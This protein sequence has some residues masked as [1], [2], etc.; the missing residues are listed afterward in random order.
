MVLGFGPDDRVRAT[1]DE[2]P[3][4]EMPADE[5]A[6][7]DAALANNKEVQRIESAM[8]AR[9][10]EARAAR[11]EW[12]PQVDLIAQYGLFAKYNNYEDYFRS[13]SGNNG[14]I[15]AS[16]QF[17]VFAGKGAK[18]RATQADLEVPG[19]DPGKCGTRSR[20]AGYPESVAGCAASRVGPRT[21]KT[22]SGIHARTTLSVCSLNP[23][24]AAPP[25][26]RWKNY[27]RSRP[28]SGWPITRRFTRW[29]A[30]N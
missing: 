14:Q 20:N 12:L 11:S 21:R 5:T 22:R 7:V 18:A 27:A 24:K 26:V 28:K 17:P 10:L 19:S 9:G 15:G 29:R 4:P 8:Q 13:S 2:P 25:C 3:A 1:P 23:K 30:H 16:I 6:S